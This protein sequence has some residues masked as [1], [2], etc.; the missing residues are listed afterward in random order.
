M[1]YLEWNNIIAEYFFNPAN[2]GKETYLYLTKDDIIQLGE[3]YIT[4]K[5]EEQIWEDF[6]G[7]IKRGL[8]GSA[9]N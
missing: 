6:T 8:P 5:A 7:A 3:L 2:A 1:T 9:G 4:N